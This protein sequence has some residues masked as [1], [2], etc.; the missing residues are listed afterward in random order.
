[1]SGGY[2]RTSPDFE[3][4]RIRSS[5]AWPDIRYKGSCFTDVIVKNNLDQS[6]DSEL[7][8]LSRI[9]NIKEFWILN[10]WKGIT[11]HVKLVSILEVHWSY[12]DLSTDNECFLSTWTRRSWVY[13]LCLH[14]CWCSYKL[15]YNDDVVLD[16][17]YDKRRS[18][19]SLKT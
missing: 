18:S 8:S 15:I 2:H 11:K 10:A 19:R 6:E 1:M 14:G 17:I 12:S 5:F 3:R 13:Y 7:T 9:K 16:M 4:S